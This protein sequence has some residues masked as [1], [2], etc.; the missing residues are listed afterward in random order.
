MLRSQV[1]AKFFFRSAFAI[2][3]KRFILSAVCIKSGF[4]E[5]RQPRSSTHGDFETAVVVVS[6]AELK[7]K[8]ITRMV[9]FVFCHH[10][11]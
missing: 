3:E 2:F 1:Y 11:A 5:A 8:K 10:Y 4:S 7:L 9:I 6:D